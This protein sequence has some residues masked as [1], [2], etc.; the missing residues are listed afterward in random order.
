MERGCP[1]EAS[2]V[3]REL[4]AGDT[5]SPIA[6]EAMDG[7]ARCRF[8]LCKK[9][10]AIRLARRVA[11]A[12]P[13]GDPARARRWSLV[14]T[15]LRQSGRSR[16]AAEVL[17]QRIA[18]EPHLPDRQLLIVSLMSALNEQ[19]AWR[20]SVGTFHRYEKDLRVSDHYGFALFLAARALEEDGKIADA[21]SFYRQSLEV[22]PNSVHACEAR[23]ALRRLD[24]SR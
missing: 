15:F 14:A 6:L 20:E 17:S 21:K 24:G 13:S 7:D 10:E 4:Y 11:E 3:L 8:M 22:A 9:A 2:R 12:T 1:A 23:A 18:A 5:A 16:E 19:S